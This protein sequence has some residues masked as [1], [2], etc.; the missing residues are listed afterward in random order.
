[1]NLNSDFKEPLN[2][3]NAEKAKY[4]VVG[5]YA[6][7]EHTEPRYT[8]DYRHLDN[9]ERENAE[10]VYAALRR[11][12]APLQEIKVDDFTNP[13][14]VYHMGRPPSRVD[15][16]MGLKMLD[17]EECWKNRVESKY[18]DVSVNFISLQDLIINKTAAGRP[19]DLAD[20]ENL[21]LAKNRLETQNQQN[22][23]V[24]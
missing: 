2:L 1:M 3:L 11:F 15:V 21:K 19:Q 6:V 16:L 8:K 4:L 20:V 24:K 17:F 12:G 9:T 18:G 14:V 7:I 23:P 22:N 13:D 10:K 5:G